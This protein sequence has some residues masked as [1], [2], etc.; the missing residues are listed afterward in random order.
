MVD[1]LGVPHK[2]LSIKT[3]SIE[4]DRGEYMPAPYYLDEI[5]PYLRPLSS[6]TKEE[7][8]ELLDLTGFDTTQITE[9]I[10]WFNQGLNI[11]VKDD[12]TVLIDWLIAKHFDY[13]GLIPMG[14]A[15]PATEGM[16]K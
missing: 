1:R 14:L 7:Y 16:Y 5:K 11:Y 8:Q 4:I 3:D 6:M 2:V 15:L 10:L 13:R 12:V 9:G